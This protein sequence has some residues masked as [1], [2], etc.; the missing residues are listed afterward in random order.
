MYR[1]ILLASVLVLLFALTSTAQDRGSIT[2]SITDPSRAAIPEATVSAMNLATGRSQTTTTSAGGFYTFAELPVG[3]YQVTVT[4]SGFE[5]EVT[6]NVRVGVDTATRLDVAMKVGTVTQKIEVT[7]A[8]ALLQSDRTELGSTLNTNQILQLPLSLAGSV[9]SDLGFITL[10]AGA[11]SPDLNDPNSIRVG[12]GL[13]RSASMLLDGGETTTASEND[14]GDFKAISVEAIQEFKV[15][16]G[17]YSAE[18]GRAGNGVWNFA[19]KSGSNQ[20]HASAFDYARNTAFNARGFYSPST[21]ITHQNDFGFTAGGPVY[22]P[23]VYDG[24]DKLFFFFSLEDS[25]FTS[26]ASTGLT[27]VPTGA[28]REG[29]FSGLV[30]S[31]GQLIPIYDPNT[32]H[33]V[34]GVTVTDPFQGNIIPQNRLDPEALALLAL[35]PVPT[36]PGITNNIESIANPGE[37][38]RIWS[39]KIDFYPSPKNHFAYFM[40]FNK[41]SPPPQVGPV[42]GPLGNVWTGTTTSKFFRFSH[43]YTVT[44]T[45][46]NHFLASVT[47][48]LNVAHSWNQTRSGANQLTAAE[49]ATILL[50]GAPGD[51]TNPGVYNFTDGYPQLGGNQNAPIYNTSWQIGD[52]LDKIKGSHQIKFGFLYLWAATSRFDISGR[53]GSVSFCD[54]NTGLPGASFQTGWSIASLLLGQTCA[55]SYSYGD[56]NNWGWP[57]YAGFVQDDWKVTHKLTINM[58]LRYEIPGVP[59]EKYGNT[60]IMDF[61]T[62]N[63]AAGGL[64]G[65]ILFGGNGAGRTGNRNWTNAREDAWGPR[66]GVAYL[67]KPDTVLRAGGGVYYEPEKWGAVDGMQ[68]GFSGDRTFSPVN[69]WTQVS[70]LAGGLPGSTPP[71]TIDPTICTVTSSL[72]CDPN[73]QY[74]YSGHA[75][76]WGTWNATVEHRFGSSTTFTAAYQ[77]SAGV[78]IFAWQEN[79]D[80]LDPKYVQ[81]YGAL[82]FQPI[83]SAAAQAAGIQLP[84]AAFP[85]SLTV[86]QALTRFPQ[87]YGLTNYANT[88]MSGHSTFHAMELSMEHQMS[89]G[90]WLQVAYTWSKLISN[91]QYEMPLEGIFDPAGDS[92]SE[93]TFDRRADKSVS[94][95]DTPHRI[96]LSY[97]YNLPVGRGRALLD[98]GGVVNAAVGGWRLSGIQQYQSGYPLTITS[99]QAD[100][101]GTTDRADVNWGTPLKNPGWNGDPNAALYINPAAYSRP[102]YLTFGDAPR[103]FSNLRGPGML[104]EDFSLAKDFFL[105]SE[106]RKLTFMANFFNTFNR[107][108]FGLPNTTV[109]STSFGAIGSQLNDPREIQFALRLQF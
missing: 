46:L 32:A 91:V 1:Y 69:S 63:P 73:Y 6:N 17:S 2:G 106:T 75:P 77:G 52:T 22:V 57:Y 25:K 68:M 101:V 103:Y 83:G 19:S 70:S 79:P 15:Q 89:H 45:F 5:S 27:S 9:R 102:A 28:M 59:S 24:R 86:G 74:P 34:N 92:V 10:T 67:V 64:L 105:G 100:G 16:T 55:A 7:A 54:G 21:T 71:P 76:R 49:R 93:N 36:L 48:I 88:D 18:Y 14:A 50:K 39:T 42:P 94:P 81:E 29:D 62:P 80:Q 43:D 72:G 37:D 98:R 87:Y 12:G 96:V 44:P 95:D 38:D 66:L 26:A 107:V 13:G 90:L 85:S 33:V 109:E 53:S 99:T 4:K 108:R 78:H 35:T 65:A 30:N 40:S 23:K 3:L 104:N 60:S 97:V 58:G 8:P 41:L 56:H 82:V 47:T 51:P 11:Y 31:T 61:N 84:Y 20:I